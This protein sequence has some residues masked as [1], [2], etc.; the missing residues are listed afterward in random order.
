MFGINRIHP[1]ATAE[2]RENFHLHYCGTC[3][4][5]GRLHGQKARIF[6]NYDTS[7]LGELLSALCKQNT[8]KKSIRPYNCLT[9]P[10]AGEIPPHLRYTA[11]I[12]VLLADLKTEDNITDSRF[13][14]TIWKLVKRIFAKDFR[15]A[16]KQLADSLPFDEIWALFRQQI[17]RERM[18]SADA[19]K[20]FTLDYFSESTS[21]IT[22]EVFRHGAIAAGLDE[23]EDSFYKIGFQF[24]QLAYLLDAL[25]DFRK[26]QKSKKFNAI[27]ASYKTNVLN[28]DLRLEMVNKLE[29][30]RDTMLN[31]LNRLPMS[32]SI[33]ESLSVRL[34]ENLAMRLNNNS[35]EKPCL[36]DENLKKIKWGEKM[37]AALD[38]TRQAFSRKQSP[39]SLGSRLK[40]RLSYLA[41]FVALMITPYKMWA[42]SSSSGDGNGCGTC[43]CIIIVIVICGGIG[44]PAIVKSTDCCGNTTYSKGNTCCN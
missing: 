41:L 14:L 43:L 19:T 2:D 10:K 8:W 40:L 3:K 31:L 9:L 21:K 13:N 25:E 32:P 18:V 42:Q 12:S 22:G 33:C 37:N 29:G 30:Y 7:F 20:R 17:D 16:Q 1:S 27:S 5:I 4:S 28:D 11:N 15:S 23:H 44:R 26:D 38:F 34:T 35:E 39:S 36:A 24:G 6:T